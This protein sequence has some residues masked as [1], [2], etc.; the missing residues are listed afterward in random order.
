MS[1]HTR[2]GFRSGEVSDCFLNDA[3]AKA[4]AAKPR[5]G[6]FVFLKLHEGMVRIRVQEL[7]LHIGA[8]PQ[9]MR[10]SVAL[11]PFRS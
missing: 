3:N 7:N 9:P 1:A 11:N 5:H 6:L 10:R 2:Q 4:Q 8:T